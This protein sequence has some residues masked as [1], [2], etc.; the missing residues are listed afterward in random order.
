MQVLFALCKESVFQV[1][2]FICFDVFIIE[3]GS[4][5]SEIIFNQS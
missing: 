5:E 1:I 4:N 3:V 2:H